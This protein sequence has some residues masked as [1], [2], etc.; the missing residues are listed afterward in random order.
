M[1]GELTRKDESHGSLDFPGRERTLVAVA[2][3]VATFTSDTVESVID[4]V[5]Q[6]SNSSFAD[7]SLGV[8][9]LQYLGDIAGV[10]LVSLT[11]YLLANFLGT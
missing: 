9:L 3:E 1:L 6:D 8:N 4:Q 2:T 5:V 10:R 11:V 7:T